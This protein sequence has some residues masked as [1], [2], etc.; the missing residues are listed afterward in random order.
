[1]PIR[2]PELSQMF[3][4]AK[5]YILYDYWVSQ[6]PLRSQ[7]TESTIHFQK[8]MRAEPVLGNYAFR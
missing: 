1:M 4:K 5:T 6:I 2:F 3:V 8:K 7:F